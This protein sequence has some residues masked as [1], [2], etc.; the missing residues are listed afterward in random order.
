MKRERRREQDLG[1]VEG[2]VLEAFRSIGYN[3][4]TDIQKKALHTIVRRIDTLLIAPTGSGKT[5]AAIIPIFTLL[6]NKK[7]G[8]KA[9]YI[10]PLRALN[11]D[12]LR[13]IVSYGEA[14]GLRV[15][16]RHGDTS[17][18]E[19]RAIAS[20]PPDVLITTPESLAIM[21]AS[22]K[23][24]KGLKSI[25]WIVIDEIH[26]LIANERGSHL[27]LSL[28]RLEALSANS[29]TRVGL[30]ATLGNIRDAADFLVGINKRCAIMI[31]NSIRKY[32]IDVIYKEGTL[33]T[34][35]KFIADYVKNLDGNILLFTNTRDEAE[36]LSTV[37]KN[38]TNVNVD[39]H[40]GSLSRVV[41]EET[42]EKLRDGNAGIVVTT[43][44]LELGLDIGSVDTVIHYGSPRQVSK[45]AQRIG[46]SKHKVG[47]SAKGLIIVNSK[48]DELEARAIISRLKKSSI[49]EQLI[50]YSAYD[51][52]AHHLVGLALEHDKVMIDDACEILTK[53]YPFKDISI[54]DIYR[55]L[56]L[57]D[58]HRLIRL[59]D[60]Y[61]KRSIRSRKY[62]FENISTI[63]DILK[64]EVVDAISNKIIGTLDQEFVGDYGEKGNVFVLKGSQW[65]IL[66][67]DDTKLRV[68]VEPIK[69]AAIN[70][71]YWVGEMIPVDYKTAQMVGRLRNDGINGVIPNDHTIVIESLKHENTIVIHA[72]F[73]NKVNNTIASLLSTIISSKIGYL[74]EARADAYRIALTSNA[75]IF[76]RHIMDCLKDD[77]ELE[78]IIIASLTNTHNLNWRVWLVA[79]RFGLIDRK[80][81][82]DKKS[83]RLLYD[84]YS[85][86]LI[87]KEAI[88]ELLHDK[89]DITNTKHVLDKIRNNSI[90]LVWLEVDNFSESA[91]SIIDHTSKFAS[92]PANIEQG[93]IELVKERLEKSKHRLICIRCAEWERIIE[94]KDAPDI[95][96][97]SLCKSRLI[98]STYTSDDRLKEIIRKRLKGVKLDD[99]EEKE[100]MR[101]WKRASLLHNFGRKALIVLSGYGVGVD[102]AARILRNCVDDS[103]IYKM[104]Y[105]AEKQY[106]TTRGFWND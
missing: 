21:L 27:S 60:D 32:D 48:D 12:I 33:N 1:S 29:I 84:R 45:L 87:V 76:E 42:E 63:P 17:T 46:R 73:G 4:L 81:V 47:Y 69:G 53:A 16:I 67:V 101:A 75:R 38:Y 8:I 96:R 50:H 92:M 105:E 15:A 106:I 52:L 22:E 13:R 80:A 77:Y 59:Y 90:R 41:R 23:M 18:K 61:Y 19:R 49:E 28:E 36:Y 74:V 70:V 51:V 89:Y 37:M 9:L 104:I 14:K 30:S 62:Y 58:K 34:I 43:S 102:T 103:N 88:R 6:D 95:L 7:R 2:E 82:Y 44:S 11:R 25:E 72:S 71:P 5:E 31:D 93:V 54:D 3:K 97:C 24:I 68:T 85:K 98:T 78:P 86:T 35:A 66:A 65:R 40:H 39:V 10:T 20:N 83:A 26:E 100:F 55:C 91:K 79:K 57:L 56:E 99:E 94:S 64:F